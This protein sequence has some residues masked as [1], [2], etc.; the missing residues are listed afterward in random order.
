MLDRIHHWPA[1]RHW[2]RTVTGATGI[3]AQRRVPRHQGARHH[4]RT[5]P[6]RSATA[7]WRIP[8]PERCSLQGGASCATRISYVG[9]HAKVLFEALPFAIQEGARWVNAKANRSLRLRATGRRGGRAPHASARRA[10]GEGPTRRSIRHVGDPRG[11]CARSSSKVRW[12]QFLRSAATGQERHVRQ[13]PVLR[14]PDDKWVSARRRCRARCG[15]VAG[16][17]RRRCANH[18]PASTSACV[19]NVEAGARR[20]RTRPA[21]APKLGGRGQGAARETFAL[22]RRP[23][24]NPIASARLPG[25]DVSYDTN[26]QTQDGCKATTRPCRPRAR[27]SRTIAA[28]T[29]RDGAVRRPGDAVAARFI[30][31]PHCTEPTSGSRI[32]AGF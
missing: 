17:S 1:W 20:S 19:G 10:K 6:S 18:S 21:A 31:A 5:N 7:S 12:G 11:A 4:H 25:G 24:P 3:T 15:P 28:R 29:P 27:L 16:V 23:P 9:G 2:R 14:V 26:S 13:K 32:S 30:L 8:A 22:K